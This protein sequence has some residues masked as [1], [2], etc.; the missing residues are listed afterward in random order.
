ME[1][2]KNYIQVYN[3]AVDFDEKLYDA[4][5]LRNDTENSPFSPLVSCVINQSISDINYVL[6]ILD[7]STDFCI[8][9]MKLNVE[10]TLEAS[11]RLFELEKNLN[12]EE[13]KILNYIQDYTQK[14]SDL[15]V[16]QS[17]NK[18]CVRVLNPNT[19]SS[20]N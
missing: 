8:S 7:N 18:T 3:L 10:T 17:K 14:I 6:D 11:K 5:E 1:T 13:I 20:L 12:Y 16:I 19:K 15:L 4:H 9:C 2:F